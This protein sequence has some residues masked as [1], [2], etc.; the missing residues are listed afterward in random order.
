MI[1][2]NR[3][4]LCK[5]KGAE[6][7]GIMQWVMTV[8]DARCAR[9]R[10]AVGR[11]WCE[12]AK[13]LHSWVLCINS[14]P[15]LLTPTMHQQ[16]LGYAIRHLTLIEGLFDPLPKHHLCVHCCFD[17]MK[18]GNPRLYALWLDEGLNKT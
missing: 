10:P 9:L 1:G 8:L 16:Q 17:A 6:T 14:F 15:E 7:W 11:K 5:T 13:A 2:A 18:N 4:P 12:A 3:N